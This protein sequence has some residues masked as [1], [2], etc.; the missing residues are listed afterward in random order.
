MGENVLKR[1][2]HDHKKR[3]TPQREAVYS[4]LKNSE[5]HPSAEEIHNKI[6]NKHPNIS[7]AT[8]YQ[9]LSIFEEIGIIKSLTVDN[10]K[11]YEIDSRFHIHII[12]PVCEKIDDLYSIKIKAFWQ[13]LLDELEINPEDEEIRVYQTCAECLNKLKKK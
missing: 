13:N 8:V 10:T 3:I 1:K 11:R 9:I 5:S 7:L 2:L 4:A 6:L 12:C